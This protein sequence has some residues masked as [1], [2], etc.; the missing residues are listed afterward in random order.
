[1]IQ[2]EGWFF[3][4]FGRR[5]LGCIAHS[6]PSSALVALHSKI[7]F[8][9]GNCSLPFQDIILTVFVPFSII[10]FCNDSMYKDIPPQF[11]FL[12]HPCLSCLLSLSV[13]DMNS[14]SAGA[15]ILSD[16]FAEQFLSVRFPCSGQALPS[17][18]HAFSHWF[19]WASQPSEAPLWLLIFTLKVIGR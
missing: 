8:S 9:S 14:R 1:M 6:A 3:F 15:L 18:V 13:A 4:F 11:L 12:D 7:N 17:D 16:A 19:Q 2:E 10:Y 5:R